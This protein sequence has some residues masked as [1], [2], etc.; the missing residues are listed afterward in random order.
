V[1]NHNILWSGGIRED[2]RAAAAEAKCLEK[3]ETRIH[4][5][6]KGVRCTIGPAAVG[7]GERPAAD[8]LGGTC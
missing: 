8:A 2:Q 7:G 3:K 1:P 5:R 4:A 6:S